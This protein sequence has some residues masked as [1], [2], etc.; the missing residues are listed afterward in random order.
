QPR[1]LRDGDAIDVVERRVGGGERL[2]HDG[3][4]EFEVAARGDLG[5]D[6]AVARM[7]LGLGGD[8]VRPDPAVLGDD[9]C[10][11]LVTARLDPEYH[12]R[13]RATGSFHMMSASS[14][15]SV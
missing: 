6:S 12:A 13:S 9:G 4:D 5:N 2:A 15:L 1:P 7:Q 14:R 8:D 11:G 3:R 10:G